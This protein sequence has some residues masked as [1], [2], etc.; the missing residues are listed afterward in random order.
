[1]SMFENLENEALDL[2]RQHKDVVD[3]LAGQA[4]KQLGDTVDGA[5]GNQFSGQV[6]S[7]EKDAPEEINKF[8]G[9]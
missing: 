3:D 4:T 9:N 6:G 1:M 7:A 8:L 5:T 2:A